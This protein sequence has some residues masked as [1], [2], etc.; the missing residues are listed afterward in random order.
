MSNDKDEADVK[1]GFERAVNNAEKRGVCAELLETVKTLWRM[2]T[3]PDYT[4]SWSTKAWII[5]GL[6]YFINPLDAVP[7]AIPVLGYVDDAA[8]IAWVLH[9]IGDEVAAY[10]RWKARA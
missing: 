7:D 4:I 3:D 9:Q 2:L 8:M 10:R 1:A 5:T 6:A